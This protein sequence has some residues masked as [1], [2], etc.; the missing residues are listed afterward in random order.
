MVKTLD[1]EATYEIARY[2]NLFVLLPNLML[3]LAFTPLDFCVL[4][5]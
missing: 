4:Y 3:K 1:H 2:I 5:S